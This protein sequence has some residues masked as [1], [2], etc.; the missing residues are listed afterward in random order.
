MDGS[1][2]LP[3]DVKKVVVIQK[4]V[5]NCVDNDFTNSCWQNY[6]FFNYCDLKK[7]F[8]FIVLLLWLLRNLDGN[9]ANPN[10]ME[11]VVAIQSGLRRF[12]MKLQKS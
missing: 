1:L 10:D 12:D 3:N 5:R 9:L 4:G 7:C 8:R 11:K 6:F 2:T